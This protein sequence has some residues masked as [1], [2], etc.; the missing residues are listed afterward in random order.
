[1]GFILYQTKIAQWNRSNKEER[2]QIMAML[3]SQQRRHVKNKRKVNRALEDLQQNHNHSWYKEIM[4][5]NKDNMDNTAIFYR[6]NEI[7]YREMQEIS[8]KFA[9]SLKAMGISKGNE[10]IACMA[11]IPEVVY[12]MLGAN[13]IGAIVNFVCE[14]FDPE[15]LRKNCYAG[16]KKVIF[17]SD[18]CYE[19]LSRYIDINK[20]EYRIIISLTDSLPD[21]KDPYKKYDTDYYDFQNNAQ[22]IKKE[23]PDICLL[24][25][26]LSIGNEYNGILSDDGIGLNTEFTITYTSGS[27]KVGWPKA[28]IHTN[29][30]YISIGR[31]HDPDLSLMPAMRNMRGLAHIP[32]HSNT[33]LVSSI[34]DTLMQKCTVACEPI[35][36]ENFFGRSLIINK[37]GFVPA[38]RSFWIRT[39]KNF[40]TDEA[41]KQEKLFFIVNAV[42]VG[43]SM[44]KNEEKY[45]NT[46]FK[47]LEAGR[48]M[49]PRILR[50]A[51]ISFGGGD[52]EHGGL[53]FTLLKGTRERMFRRDYGLVPFQLAELAILNEDG[54]ECTYGK[55]GI[56][57]ANSPC[58]MKEY[59]DDMESTQKF[60]VRDVY[61]RIW[62]NC[63]VWAYMDKHGRIHMIGRV[64]SELK[65]KNGYMLPMYKIS[66][67]VLSNNNILSCETVTNGERIVSYIEKY[68]GKEIDEDAL[69][70]KIKEVVIQEYGKE[71]MDIYS[72][73]L[74]SNEQSFVLTKSGK[75]NVAHLENMLNIIKKQI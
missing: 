22:K 34:S 23:N 6:G 48:D 45:I 73:Q 50:P 43:E 18:N 66:N 38:T 21:G 5:R 28:I 32:T 19:Q 42:V 7:S 41:L 56:L 70:G 26:F 30:S 51:T 49:L 72:I 74:L 59:R 65:L 37:P 11:N 46:C 52:C 68:P 17:I 12:L 36:N 16:E 8:I 44:S 10:I 15:C 1:M 31:F 71:M 25:D 55:V 62:A 14:E 33:D 3:P 27:T 2:G 35:Y 60:F 20:F 64:G 9:R 57:A 61:G 69:I 58:T 53:F 75:R 47:K 67:I 4:L 24:K 63:F 40:E 39:M 54:T 29:R 13:K